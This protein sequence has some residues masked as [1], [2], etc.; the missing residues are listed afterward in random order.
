[1]LCFAAVAD[2]GSF[3]AAAA[4]LGCSKAHVSR[5]VAEL[6]R[7]LGAQLLLRTTRRLS[8]TPLGHRYAEQAARLRA[9]YDEAQQLIAA[10]RDEVRGLLRITSATT[11]G[12]VFLVDLIHAFQQQYPQVEVELDT[13]IQTHDLLDG[14]YDFA[15]RLS[16]TLDERLVARAIGL[17]REVPVAAPALLAAFGAPR[18]PTDLA[19][20]PAL[21][22]SHFRDDPEWV[23]VRGRES[24]T[25][26]LRSPLA[27]NNFNALLRA[28]ERGVA[29][30]RLP[31]YLV[32]EAVDAG[33]LQ[34]LLPDWDLAQQPIYLVH[35]QRRHPTRLQ[36]AFRA[37][38][39]AWF[40]APE[41]QARLR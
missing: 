20:L 1:M 32:R 17:A 21:R 10:E 36:A 34:R 31:Q 28:A 29:I 4:A 30:A 16:R 9:V 8:L 19:S 7:A 38:V 27:I 26:R 25:V 14:R 24:E 5:Q 33:R 39:L 2:R 22:N 3:T 37:F 23:F 6:E 41:R 11:F 13:S 12:E 40:A 15:F 35:P 18:R